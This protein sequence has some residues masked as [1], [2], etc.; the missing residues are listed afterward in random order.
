MRA[1]IAT[2]TTLSGDTVDLSTLSCS[3]ISLT[4]GAITITQNSLNIQGPSRHEVITGYYNGV[5]ENDRIFKHTGTGTLT[6]QYLNFMYANFAP[7]SGDASGGCIYSKGNVFLMDSLVFSCATKTSGNA[8]ARG[9]GIYTL[10]KLTTKYSQISGNTATGYLSG[11]GGAF[12]GHTFRAEH[13]TING[14]RAAGSHGVGGGIEVG[15]GANIIN[16][17]ISGNIASQEDGGMYV[18]G[19][20]TT[21]TL[22][23]NSSTISGNVAQ[24]GRIGGVGT[25]LPTTVQNSTIAFNTAA[26]THF[27]GSTDY[28][29]PGLAV[30]NSYS[31]TSLAVNLQ[32][33]ILS[34]NTYGTIEGDFSAVV[35]TGHTVTI[36]SANSL[37]RAS[38][39]PQHPATVTTSCPLLGPLRANGGPTQTHALMSRSPAIDAGNNAAGLTGDQR[40]TAYAR[41]SG[42]AADIGAYEV[43]QNDIIFNSGFDGCP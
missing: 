6:L 13:S 34:N 40:G 5:T 10:G 22:Q 30:L 11:G 37:I 12:V 15:Y 27:S 33:S 25:T 9:G 4:T 26:T 43:Q 18:G 16:S 42:S 24:T 35:H 7:A 41:V 36:T 32:S 20:A 29:A 8:I 1:V 19:D 31:A 39:G 28:R 38:L 23:I 2:P 14:N 17:T 3:T 21:D